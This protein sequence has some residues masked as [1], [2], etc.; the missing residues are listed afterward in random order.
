MGE[1]LVKCYGYVQCGKRG[2]SPAREDRGRGCRASRT[3]KMGGALRLGSH[4][5]H[6][7]G[8]VRA[9]CHP[10]SEDTRD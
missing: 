6:V 9:P 5:G 3:A 2:E 4:N 1:D 10:W 8:E 7:R